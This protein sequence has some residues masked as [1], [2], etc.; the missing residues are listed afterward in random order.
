MNSIPAYIDRNEAIRRIRT[1]LRARSGR[2]WSV[3]GGRGTAW[4]WIHIRAK[5]GVS[6]TPEECQEL[7]RLLGGERVYDGGV[8]VP[9][10]GAHY[11]EYVERA[12]GRPVT[13][14]AEDYWD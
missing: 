10:S 11:R 2:N 3:R 8:S 9:S 7:S 13:K 1:G 4:G 6:M 14:I 12:E 5:A